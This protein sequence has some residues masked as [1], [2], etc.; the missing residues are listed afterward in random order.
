MIAI[1]GTGKM[2]EA[3]LSGLLRDFY[4]T[5]VASLT[6]FAALSFLS[7]AF[8]LLVRAPRASGRS[9]PMAA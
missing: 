4:G 3:L 5:Y 1:L 8:A 9:T 2:G 7:V 6:C